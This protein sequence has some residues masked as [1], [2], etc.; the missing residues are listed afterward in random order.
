MAR[1]AARYKIPPA[2]PQSRQR[3]VAAAVESE[4]RAADYLERNRVAWE[5]WA[6]DYVTAGRAA[7]RETELYWG[8]WGLPE[9]ELQLFG[10]L[11]R[12]ADAIEL[13]CG[14]AG[15]SAWLARNGARPVAVDIA[16]PQ[17]ETVRRLQSE[18]AVDF[19]LV[20]ANAEDLAFDDGSFDVAVSEYGASLW[21]DPREWLPEAHRLL[22]PGGLLV[23]VTNGAML[24]ACTPEE[25]GSADTELHRDYFSTD[26]VEFSDD[27][28]VEFHPTHGDWIRLV[29]S[30]GFVVEDLIEIRPPEGASP[31]FD[32]VSVDWARR[33]PSE[34]V[35]VARKS[36]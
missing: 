19:P 33:W 15:I 26:R 2:A 1:A 10:A 20:C 7:W 30:S 32:F 14:T 29:H 13:G 11:P 36:G 4:R 18:F 5:D 8:I 35:W 34:E 25:G 24:I 31:R 27:G 16:R 9:S 12:D 3:T 21:C 17:L 28:P 23:F 6:R 22:R